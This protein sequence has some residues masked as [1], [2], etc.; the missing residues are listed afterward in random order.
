MKGLQKISSL[1]KLYIDH[2]NI[3]DEAADDI[4]SVIWCN[5]GLKIRIYGNKFHTETIDR[6]LTISQKEILNFESTYVSIN[7]CSYVNIDSDSDTDS[8]TVL[9]TLSVPPDV[10]SNVDGYITV[11]R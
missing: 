9:D 6:L 5:P 3:G 1:T 4:V 8:D 7:K 10:E 2:N 11:L